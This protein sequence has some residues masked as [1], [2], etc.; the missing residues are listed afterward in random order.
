VLIPLPSQVS[1]GVPGA[2][3]AVDVAAL[4]GVEAVRVVDDKG[5][6]LGA[7]GVAAVAGCFVKGVAAFTDVS[8]LAPGEFSTCDFSCLCCC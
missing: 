7:N 6:F 8:P 1:R 3:V 2:I 5:V 4:L